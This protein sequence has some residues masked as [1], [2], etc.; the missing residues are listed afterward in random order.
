MKVQV[1]MAKKLYQ[2]TRK[3]KNITELSNSE[4]IMCKGLQKRRLF[5]KL[6]RNLTDLNA[7]LKNN[8]NQ[9]EF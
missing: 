1:K 6:L 7:L 4:R 5:I 2:E 8:R 3:K 9:S